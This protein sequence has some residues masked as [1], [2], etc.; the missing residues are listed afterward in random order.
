MKAEMKDALKNCEDLFGFFWKVRMK[1]NCAN[2]GSLYGLAKI[3]K[4]G[5]DR[6]RPI[7]S[8]VGTPCYNTAK[9]LSKEFASMNPPRGFVIK[10][11]RELIHSLKDIVIE[12]DEVMVSF[13]IDS[14]FPSVPVPDSIE[15]LQ[16][17]LETQSSIHPMRRAGMLELTKVCMKQ[18]YFKFRGKFYRQMSGTAM[19]NPMSPL[20]CDLY[21]GDLER[22]IS[23]NAMFPRFWKRYVDDVFAIVKKIW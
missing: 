8:C 23:E 11:S 20:I 5:G 12:H 13:D 1:V 6:M 16:D 3:H 9:W 19:E 18:S 2:V 22:K 21:V 10:N 14:Y 7:N 15:L 17:W 4:V